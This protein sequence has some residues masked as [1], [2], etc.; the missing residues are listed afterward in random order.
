M[1]KFAPLAL[2]LAL[3]SLAGCSTFGDAAPVRRAG[4]TLKERAP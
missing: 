2:T 1:R 4:P 3:A